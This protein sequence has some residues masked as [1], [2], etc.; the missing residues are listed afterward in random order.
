[1]SSLEFPIINITNRGLR[2]D[3]TVAAA[4]L[5][6]AEAP[7]LPV[8]E[9]RVHGTFSLLIGQILFQGT[10]EAEFQH[11]CDRCL[12]DARF[13]VS[14]PVVWTFEEGQPR[15][16]IEQ[17]VAEAED[18]E[19]V[20]ALGVFFY[21]GTAINLAQPVWDEVALAMPGKF[22]CREEC[23]GL[24]PV[25][26]G[27]RNTDPCTCE[28][29]STNRETPASNSGFAGLKEMFPDLPE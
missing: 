7:A 10:V 21:D 23:R 12:E 24:C 28:E 2:V 25:C 1:M 22:I 17:Q 26:G 8:D 6:P 27:N 19:E 5:K 11:R 29:N 9:V 16:Y 13:P 20:E 14:A 18:D 3:V 4:T 15:D